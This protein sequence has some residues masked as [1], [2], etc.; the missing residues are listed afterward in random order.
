MANEPTAIVSAIHGNLLALQACLA[1]AA[2]RGA[3]RVWC[4]GDI[5]GYGARPLECLQLLRDRDA[6]IIRG[7]HEQAVLDGAFGF[8]PLAAAAIH[9]T[10]NQL[11]RAGAGSETL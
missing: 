10:R 3:T 6:L 11:A 5:V 1:D 7:N 9:W 8:N 4:L 2:A